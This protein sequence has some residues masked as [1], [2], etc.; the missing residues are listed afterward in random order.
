[1]AGSPILPRNAADPLGTDAR[2]RRA[3]KD[4]AS[5]LR[6]IQRGTL[7]ILNAIPYKVV[8][9]NALQHNSTTYRF[10]LDENVLARMNAEIALIV[11]EFLL[12]G[13]YQN[14]W[15]MEAYVRPA[16][17]QGTAQSVSNLTVQ[18]GVYAAA[19]PTL[20]SVLL[21]APYQRRIGLVRARQ[22]ENMK[23]FAG[24][25]KDVLGSTLARGMAAGQNPRVIAKE[26]AARTGVSLSRANTIART[27]IT[28][29]L[30]TARMDETE[31]AQERLGIQTKE[32]HLSAFSP[33]TRIE[34]ARRSGTLH[35]IQEQR[36]WWSLSKNACNCK[37]T[38]VS[39]L[40]DDAGNPLTPSIIDRA[41]R[42]K[43][44]KL[45]SG[46]IK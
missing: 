25:M 43:Q 7:R 45:A 10:E 2:E 3:M 19:R 28:G 13:G 29:A 20:E 34:H 1:M 5:R 17:V 46:K 44:E 42:I 18:S 35:T 37:C 26:I 24:S 9:I 27:E 11:D 15:F 33:T 6:N 23:G 22:F 41:K 16:Y 4:F 30:R 31:D 14:L 32:M 12:E 38:T 21:S 40:V 8:T 39:V 36:E